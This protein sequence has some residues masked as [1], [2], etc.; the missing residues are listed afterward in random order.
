M[1]VIWVLSQVLTLLMHEFDNEGHNLHLNMLRAFTFFESNLDLGP[2]DLY[3]G[4]GQHSLEASLTRTL[5]LPTS[6]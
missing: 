3:L 2:V 5:D 1:Q 6:T 4:I